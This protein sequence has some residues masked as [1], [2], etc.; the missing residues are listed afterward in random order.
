M[1]ERLATRWL[2]EDG[3]IALAH[4]RDYVLA[5]RP[6]RRPERGG[7]VDAR[8]VPEAD[9]APDLAAAYAGIAPS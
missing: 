1:P 9:A 5:R 3:R 4:R 6:E 7:G 2:L 8:Q